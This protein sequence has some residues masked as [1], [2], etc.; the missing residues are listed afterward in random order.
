MGAPVNS[1]GNE[2][3]PSTALNGNIYF[4][5]RY[6]ADICVARCEDGHYREP[7]VLGNEVNSGFVELDPVI[8]PDERFLIFHSN[9]PGGFGGNDLYISFRDPE[10][11]QW[12][13]AVNMG[14]GIN[15]ENSD[16]CARLSSD[17][18]YLFFSRKNL[19]TGKSDF[20]WVSAVIIEN[21]RQ[22]ALKNDP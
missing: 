14:K 11:N 3:H 4:F 20:Y 6:G 7:E 15:T 22:E 2:I 10:K 19:K 17:G 16:Y 1:D 9:R 13:K 5:G 18:K 8:A 21:R 12:L